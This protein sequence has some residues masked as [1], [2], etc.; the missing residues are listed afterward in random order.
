MPAPLEIT[1]HLFHFGLVVLIWLVQLVIY[2]SLAHIAV[3]RFRDWHRRYTERVSLV[4]V[5]LMFAQ[6]GL[7]ALRLVCEAAGWTG[8]FGDLEPLAPTLDADVGV[9]AIV[10]AGRMEIQ[11]VSVLVAIQ[12]AAVWLVTFLISVPIHTKLQ[13]HGHSEALVEKL[14]LT[15]WVRTGLWTGIFLLDFL[16]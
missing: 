8:L 12:V 9:G 1:L 5:P 4:V 14:V 3:D 11:L 6:L 10:A 2:P 16:Y 15:N 7:V 13:E